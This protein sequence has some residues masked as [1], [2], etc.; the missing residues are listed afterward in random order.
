MI[1]LGQTNRRDDSN[2]STLLCLY[3][4][5][6]DEGSGTGW[7]F[8]NRERGP[9]GTKGTHTSLDF[10]ETRVPPKFCF[11]KI[12]EVDEKKRIKVTFKCLLRHCSR[13]EWVSDVK[14]NSV[15]KSSRS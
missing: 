14:F 13:A 10:R 9:P 2:A 7:P 1:Y 8:K 3:P 12:N 6:A 5:T 15:E 11:G 4:D